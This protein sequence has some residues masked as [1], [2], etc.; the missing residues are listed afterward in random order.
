[1]PIDQLPKTFEI[2]TTLDLGEEKWSVVSKQMV[3]LAKT[4]LIDPKD[5]LFSLPTISN[6]IGELID[7]DT[8]ENVLILHE[9]D[10]IVEGKIYYHKGIC[11]CCVHKSP[12]NCQR[13]IRA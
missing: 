11:G 1:M 2:H 12:G 10:W 6:D 5:V 8:L 7:T 3:I 4:Q 13:G 9:D